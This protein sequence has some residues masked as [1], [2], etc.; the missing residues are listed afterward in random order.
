MLDSNVPKLSNWS[1]RHRPYRPQLSLS[2]AHYP[3]APLERW[4]SGSG[5][6]FGETARKF[7]R[8][9]WNRAKPDYYPLVKPDRKVWEL[10]FVQRHSTLPQEGTRIFTKR[11]QIQI[12][13]DVTL[14]EIRSTVKGWGSLFLHET[15]KKAHLYLAIRTSSSNSLPYHIVRKATS[16]SDLIIKEWYLIL[17][18]Y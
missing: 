1:S 16:P 18:Y 12:G 8:R 2:I 13:T 3:A 9:E 7:A 6:A 17:I 5:V 15:W 11:K 4:K 14:R 10:V